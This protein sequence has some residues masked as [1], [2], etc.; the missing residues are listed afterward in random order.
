MGYM[1]FSD[2]IRRITKVGTYSDHHKNWLFTIAQMKLPLVVVGSGVIALIVTLITF[3]FNPIYEA[4]TLIVLDGDLNKIIKGSEISFPYTTAADYIRFEFFANHSVML[5]HSP[6]LADQFVKRMNIKDSS[7]DLI[8]TDY[9]I[10]PNLFRLVFSNDGQGIKAQWVSD[11]QQFSISGYSKDPDKAVAY[12][13]NYAESFLK[14]N[15]NNPRNAL[16]II[17]DRLDNQISEIRRQEDSIDAQIKN[18]RKRYR[19]S[20]VDAESLSLI[21]KIYSIRSDLDSAHLDEKAYQLRIDQ[22]YRKAKDKEALKK[23]KVIMD[24]NPTI[25][26]L[27]AKMEELTRTLAG[28]SVELTKEHPLYKV[29]EKSL[30]A[31]REALEKEAKESFYLHTDVLTAMLKYDLNHTIYRSQVEHYNALLK[32][33]ESRQ[34]ELSAAQLELGKLTDQKKQLAALLSTALTNHSN[35]SNVMNKPLSSFRVVSPASIDKTNLKYYKHFPKRKRILALTFLASFFILSFLVIGRE[36]YAN[37]LYRGWQLSSLKH[38]VNYTDVPMLAISSVKQMNAFDAAICKYIHKICLATNDA[39]IIRVVSGV[40]GEGKASI[41]RALAAY[42][43]KMGKT[44]LLVDGDLTNRSS[45]IGFGFNDRPGLTDHIT[46]GKEIKDIIVHDQMYNIPFVPA[47]SQVNLDLKPL[48][49]KPLKELFAVLAADFE[50]IIFIDVPFSNDRLLISDMLPPHDD[51]I[52]V[53]SGEHSVF[54]IDHFTGMYE[55]MKDKSIRRGIV[56]N[57]IIA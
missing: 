16:G 19:I 22:L 24:S 1:R 27:K 15:A 11:T 18:I 13:R 3:L 33:A 30:N 46:G 50:K 57:K 40:K 45:T 28:Y 31:T 34:E 55:F 54:E 21:N 4:K 52:V 53:E 35:V 36:L 41:A 7:G 6:Q 29:T 17:V 51:I 39:Q 37:K 10:K 8:F 38:P 2:L 25:T 44:V 14:E 48:M 5:M 42:H 23:Y 20:D 12:S 47:G 56:V 26:T 43:Q 32:A 9:F 49:L